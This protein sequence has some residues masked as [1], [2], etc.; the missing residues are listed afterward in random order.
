VYLK[1]MTKLRS[2]QIKGT[3]V[4]AEGIADLQKSLPN[5]KIYRK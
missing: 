1:G 4:T 5:C 2:L 3:K